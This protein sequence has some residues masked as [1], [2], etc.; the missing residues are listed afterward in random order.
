MHASTNRTQRGSTK[1]SGDKRTRFSLRAPAAN[2]VCLAGSFNDWNPAALQMERSD[3]GIW[4]AELQLAPG[5]YEY[6][7][8]V[9]G[10]WCCDVTDTGP[11]ES[12]EGCVPNDLGTMNRC[13]EVA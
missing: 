12:A 13:I 7:F 9:D 8:V 10:H 4:C 1:P 2:A 3:D 11:S 6:K 5:H